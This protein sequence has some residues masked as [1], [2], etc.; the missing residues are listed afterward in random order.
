MQGSLTKWQSLDQLLCD[1]IY[2]PLMERAS[3]QLPPSQVV[4]IMTNL[5]HF[6]EACR[7]LQGELARARSSR[8]RTGPII[9][10]ATE[11]F[12]AGRRKAKDRIFELINSRIDDLL[13]NANYRWYIC[14]AKSCRQSKFMLTHLSSQVCHG[15]RIST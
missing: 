3:L 11:K 1:Q 7:E 4:Q 15:T 2:K 12:A 8:S 6:E 5:E 9:L 10:E 13:D 14:L